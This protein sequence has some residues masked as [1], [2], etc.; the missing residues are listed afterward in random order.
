MEIRKADSKGRLTGF[1]PGAHYEIYEEGDKSY[2]S[3]YV[4]G[5]APRKTENGTD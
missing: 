5:F 4:Y 1:T 3:I 2:F